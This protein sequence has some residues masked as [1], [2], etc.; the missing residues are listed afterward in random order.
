MNNKHS[1]DE[2]RN[3]DASTTCSR[4][5]LLKKGCVIAVCSAAAGYLALA[6]ENFPLSRRD[7]TGKRSKPAEKL[8][9]LPDFRIKV[10]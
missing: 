6:P 10:S 1:Q 5:Y 8:F 4:R 9:T 3:T 7:N 2:K